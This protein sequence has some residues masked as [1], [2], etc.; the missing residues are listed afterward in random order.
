MTADFFRARLERKIDLHNP[1]VALSRRMPWDQI[2][3]LAPVLAHKRRS[4]CGNNLYRSSLS[5][6]GAG[7]TNAGLRHRPIRLMVSLLYL[8]HAYNLSDEALVE[9]WSQNVVW[10]YS[11]GMECCVP[12]LPCYAAQMG[13][14]LIA[15]GETGFEELL[16]ATIETA[17][18]TKTVKPAKFD[19]VIVDSTVQRRAIA[20]LVGR[21]LLGVARHKV[22]QAA[23][24]V[25][26]ELKQTFVKEGKELRRRAG[27]Y[28]HAKQYRRPRKVVKRQRTILGILIL[29]V[30]R[31]Q[32]EA[33]SESPISMMR[34]QTWLARAE[35]IRAQQPKDENELYALHAWEVECIRQRESQASV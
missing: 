10:H 22:V 30:Q 25:G 18:T 23:K 27:G 33:M 29:E 1:L 26:I 6:G 32:V 9:R 21:R 35:R 12:K 34:L 2:E 8:K 3:A 24:S 19:R 7:V 15:I 16:K 20:Y 17:V 14:I 13:R 31:K 5:I 4:I 28:A 11:S